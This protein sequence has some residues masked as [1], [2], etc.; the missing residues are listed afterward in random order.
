MRISPCRLLP[1]LSSF[2][3]VLVTVGC[4]AQEKEPFTVVLLPDTQN[5]SDKCPETYMA[6]TEWIKAK[7]KEENI[8]FV[9]HLGDIVQHA[10]NEDEWQR[11]DRAQKVLDGIV[12]YS[13][14]PGNHDVDKQFST[15]GLKKV[16]KVTRGT[17]LYDKYF[18]PQRFKKY[19]WYGGHKGASN[20]NNYCFFEGGGMKFMVLSLEFAPSDETLAWAND[21]VDK[22]RD[23]QV[24]VATHFHLRVG[25]RPKDVDPYGLKGNVGEAVWNKLIRKHENIF[26]IVCGHVS[27][28]FHQTAVNDAGRRVHE[29]LADYQRLPNGGDGWLQ[30]VKFVPAEG[31]IKVIAYSPKLDKYDDVWLDMYEGKKLDGYKGEKT[32][33]L[34]WDMGGRKLKKAG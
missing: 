1:A 21:V 13:M 31:K 6:Q 28:V 19:P 16:T 2:A 3:V 34:E 10:E 33:T 23:R 22:H 4:A 24:I 15:K 30:L 5:Y 29:I 9:I 27:G 20:A 18:G 26:M 11:A 32:Y 25:S 17:S 12:P 8:K 14:A 7:A